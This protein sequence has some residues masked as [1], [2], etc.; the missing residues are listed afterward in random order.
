[1]VLQRPRPGMRPGNVQPTRGEMFAERG[2][3]KVNL[4]VTAFPMGHMNVITSWASD[5]KGEGQACSTGKHLAIIMPLA[6]RA[7]R[8]CGAAPRHGRRPCLGSAGPV[9]EGRNSR[10]GTSASGRTAKACRPAAGRPRKA[11]SIYAQKMRGLPRQE[12]PGAA[13]KRGARQRARQVGTDHGAVC[14][15]RPP[16]SS[17][18]TRRAMP[19]PQPKTLT[20]DEVYAL[21]AYILVSNKVIGENEVMN[22]EDL[23]EGAGCQTGMG[24]SA[25]NPDK[26]LKERGGLSSPT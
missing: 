7:P 21:T 14:A 15:D 11:Q 5:N 16:R 13:Q 24:S 12:R 10:C 25:D 23:A 17:T 3:P 20:S 8:F 2:E 22:A 4:P 9:S 19:W 6:L 18:F 26:H 1:V